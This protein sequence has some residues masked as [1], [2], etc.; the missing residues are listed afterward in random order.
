[1]IIYPRKTDI[2]IN[3][4]NYSEVSN[5]VQLIKP[6]EIYYLAAFHHSSEDNIYNYDVIINK[7]YDINVLSYCNFLN[8]ITI[9]K[10]QLT[11][12]YKRIFLLPIIITFLQ[13][14]N[15]LK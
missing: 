2:I 8:A 9:K 4:S 15:K 3:I 6:D 14:H 12:N 7:S 13:L 1:M 11:F 5:F 10:T